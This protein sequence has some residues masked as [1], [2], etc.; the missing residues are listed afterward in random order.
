MNK[1]DLIETVARDLGEFVTRDNPTAVTPTS[2]DANTL[3]HPSSTQLNGYNYFEFGATATQDRVIS[4][5]DPANNRLLVAESFSPTPSTN[6]EF[7]IFKSFTGNDF[8][9]AF[10]Q[11]YAEY[12]N[13]RNNLRDVWD[14]RIAQLS[15]MQTNWNSERTKEQSNWLDIK[16]AD[17]VNWVAEQTN[18]KVSLDE[19]WIISHNNIK[20]K[21]KNPVFALPTLSIVTPGS[22]VPGTMPVGTLFIPSLS[23]LSVPTISSIGSYESL[24]PDD[25]VLVNTMLGVLSGRKVDEDREWQQKF[26]NY[27]ETKANAERQETE[28]VTNLVTS[29]DTT[30]EQHKREFDLSWEGHKRRYEEE[31]TSLRRDYADYRAT[32]DSQWKQ[33]IAVFTNV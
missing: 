16:V 11:A 8:E 6:S 32:V 13:F 5:F 21:F 28:V 18:W 30:W 15:P 24:I 10:R 9:F 12:Y 26:T 14:A 29:W 1:I 17:Q 22:L 23:L 27:K 20:V 3:I 7:I 25:T 31:W 19:S 33:I 4:E 2:V